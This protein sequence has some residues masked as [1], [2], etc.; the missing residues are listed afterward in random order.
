MS[1]TRAPSLACFQMFEYWQRALEPGLTPAASSLYTPA[2]WLPGRHKSTSF[3]FWSS[4]CIQLWIG[5]FSSPGGGALRRAVGRRWR[6]P[7]VTVG[8]TNIMGGEC[9]I[10]NRLP[11][12][13]PGL[14]VIAAAARTL[15]AGAV[16]GALKRVDVP[17]VMAGHLNAQI[18]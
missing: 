7:A 6:S 15:A 14:M 3:R 1:K 2:S 17:P 8:T 11:S 18:A 16:L 13:S 9:A 5:T 10:D 12:A 4:P